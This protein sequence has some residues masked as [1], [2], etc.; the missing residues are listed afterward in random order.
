[1]YIR[2]KRPLWFNQGGFLQ[3]QVLVA[4]DRLFKTTP[5][6]QSN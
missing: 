5:A 3:L 4:G 6:L 2:V 1:M